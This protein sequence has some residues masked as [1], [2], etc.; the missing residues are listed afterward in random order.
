MTTTTTTTQTGT[1]LTWSNQS[2]FLDNFAFLDSCQK[3]KSFFMDYWNM[4]KE[5]LG[6]EIFAA[7]D[8][9]LDL[10]RSPYALYGVKYIGLVFLAPLAAG[11]SQP[12]TRTLT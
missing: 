2:S 5:E 6:G 9:H 7:S 12:V 3:E 10:I 11:S 8:P 4:M 1:T